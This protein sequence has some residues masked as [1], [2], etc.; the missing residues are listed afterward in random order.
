MIAEAT[1]SIYALAA[2][3]ST[4]YAGRAGGLYRS[5]DGG[6]T[7]ED[8][9]A[10][11]ERPP[12]LAV[13]AIGLAG[14]QLFAATRG[15]VLRSEDDGHTWQVVGLAAPPPPLVS[16]LALSPDF[17]RDGVLLA[18]TA[19]DGVFVSSDRGQSWLAW[20]FGLLDTNVYSLALSPGFARDA[21]VLIGTESG[22]FSSTSG[23][24]SW[25]ET[26]FPLSAAPVLSVCAAGGGRWYAGTE[27]HGLFQSVDDG[28]TWQPR[29]L[30]GPLT[31]IN[32]LHPAATGDLYVLLEDR[33]LVLRA[34]QPVRSA[35]PWAAP[36]MALLVD[37][38][39]G[40]ALV[41][42]SDGRLEWVTPL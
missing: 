20:N 23:G 37:A 41:G 5:P 10:G 38:P 6:R 18:A 21:R 36:A 2:A 19:E 4:L 25:Q 26:A 30:P 32:S 29:P 22:I 31:A 13:T 27:E 14:A 15:A 12:G 1:E 39:G 9:L 24:R 40:R 33:L 17:A 35:G 28:H 34:D 3:G 7:W 11:L 16:A 8:A 42:G